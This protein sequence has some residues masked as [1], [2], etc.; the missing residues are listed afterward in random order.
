M[1]TPTAT[2][3]DFDSDFEKAVSER[4]QALGYEIKPQVGSAGFYVD[5]AVVDPDAPGRF[6]LGIECDGA[7]YHSA[8]SARDRDR[9]RQAVLEGL[10][11][12][13]HRIW[14]TDWFKHP[15]REL[16][17]VVEAINK[18]KM[19]PKSHQTNHTR[20]EEREISR[21]DSMASTGMEIIKPYQMANLIISLGNKELHE[22]PLSIIASWVSQ[23][24]RGEGPV[25][26]SEVMK[27]IC[28]AAGIKRVGNRIQEVIERSIHILNDVRREGEF[29]WVKDMVV[30]EVRNR[31]HVVTKKI[32][33]I[34]P[35]EVEQAILKVLKGSY[36]AEEEVIAAEV[37]QMIGFARV[38]EEMKTIVRSRLATLVSQNVVLKKGAVYVSL[39]N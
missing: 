15:D 11:W 25:H 35:Q 4:L 6:L 23:V 9:L 34:S 24:V 13:I 10:G 14:S 7:M 1:D 31:N 39:S 32:Q 21:K 26:I 30:P 17:R 2:G 27:R 5:L 8:R 22:M 18:A 12:T 36:G 38:T 19:M 29:L 16:K 20:T 28:E 3:R 33:L 37:W